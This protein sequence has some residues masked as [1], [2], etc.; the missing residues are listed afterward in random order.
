MAEQE[1][2]L[3]DIGTVFEVT[4]TDDGVVLPIIS[5]VSMAIYFRKPS[6]AVLTKIAV[7]TSD[8]TDGKIQY[9]SEAGDLDESGGETNP[10]QIQGRVQLPSGHWSSTVGTFTVGKNLW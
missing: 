8:G 4:L 5:P 7:L 3:N 1:V 10:W 6:G 9:V 2:K